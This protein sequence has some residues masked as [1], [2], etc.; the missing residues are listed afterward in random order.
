[1]ELAAYEEQ[2][3][4][5][6]EELPD[7]RPEEGASHDVFTVRSTASSTSTTRRLKAQVE[8]ERAVLLVHANMLEKKHQMEME[9]ASFKAKK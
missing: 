1:M 8:A 5:E 7:V 4:E 2:L 6:A 9:E 3:N